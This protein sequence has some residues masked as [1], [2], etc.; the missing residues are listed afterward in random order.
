MIYRVITSDNKWY[1]EWKR[2]VQ[3]VATND[4]ESSFRL[5][6]LFLR[7]IEEPTTKNSKKNFLNFEED[8]EEDLIDWEQKQP[9]KKKY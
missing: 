5:I 7:I 1:K 9:S 6:F 3:W 8:L 2:V 4:N